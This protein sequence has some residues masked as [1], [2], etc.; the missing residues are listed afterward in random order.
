VPAKV[1]DISCFSQ[2]V[3]HIAMFPHLNSASRRSPSNL[4]V[5]YINRLPSA[6]HLRFLAR[7]Q[8]L[9]LAREARF[10]S[11]GRR[12]VIPNK[13]WKI[14]VG[15]SRKGTSEPLS[16]KSVSKNRQR[17]SGN[18]LRAWVFGQQAPSAR[19][20]TLPA[21][22]KDHQCFRKATERSL[23]WASRARAVTD[24]PTI[25][26]VPN[27]LHNF[28]WSGVPNRP[29]ALPS[30]LDCE[31]GRARECTWREQFWTDGYEETAPDQACLPGNSSFRVSSENVHRRGVPHN[32]PP[33]RSIRSRQQ[34]QFGFVNRFAPGSAIRMAS[35]SFEA[36]ATIARPSEAWNRDLQSVVLFREPRE[37]CHRPP[38]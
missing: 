7:R 4:S 9:G 19:S 27:G 20:R 23:E 3:P 21:I 36:S 30:I 6:N 14:G 29:T 12:A 17:F 33:P 28:C 26:S 37:T 16:F 34:A 18:P 22:G 13:A 8:L 11:G 1:T 24:L 35:G 2:S 5:M 31:S 15:E 32:L 10:V 25:T 38:V